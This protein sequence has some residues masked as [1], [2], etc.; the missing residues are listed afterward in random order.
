MP[1]AIAI[2]IVISIAAGTV[3]GLTSMVLKH[4][5]SSRAIGTGG[6]EQ[7]I[8]T[9]ELRQ[10]MREAASEAVAPLEARIDELQ[11]MLE[12]EPE[13]TRALPQA[14]GHD[15]IDLDETAGSGVETQ[16]RQQVR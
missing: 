7:G 3:L 8:R 15:M 10:M 12:T 9:S 14:G 2:I 5:R 13:P 1:E 6:A 16:V 4:R 11:M